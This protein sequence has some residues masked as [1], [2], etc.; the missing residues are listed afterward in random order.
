MNIRKQ[1]RNEFSARQNIIRGE[2]INFSYFLRTSMNIQKKI[3]QELPSTPSWLNDLSAW[4]QDHFL[5]EI[6]QF[7]IKKNGVIDEADVQLLAIL[8]TQ[9]N[10]Y[11]KSIR[12]INIS[13]S[14]IAFNN[15]IT[16]GPNPHITIADKSLNRIIQLMKELELSPKSK[17]GFRSN[18]SPSEEL[19]NFLAG[20]F[21]TKNII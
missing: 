18:S 7:L 3:V 13:G 2:A 6:K 14:V 4:D 1:S 19:L 17:D 9:I 15:G 8:V 10:L 12:E 20:P 16:L 11:I 5:E 21:G